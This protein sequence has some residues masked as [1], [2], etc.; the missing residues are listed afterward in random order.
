MESGEQQ[1]DTVRHAISAAEGLK[2]LLRAVLAD[3]EPS[4]DLLRRASFR[5]VSQ[6]AL[7]SLGQRRELYS[8]HHCVAKLPTPTEAVGAL[9]RM[10][11][12]DG[13]TDAPRGVGRRWVARR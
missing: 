7:L 12:H 5:D 6:H 2:M 1:F 8:V 9:V 10:G 13:R 3:T 4:R 11:R